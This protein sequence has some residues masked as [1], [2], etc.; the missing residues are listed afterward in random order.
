[1]RGETT[2][3]QEHFATERTM[4][5]SAIE[6]VVFLLLVVGEIV[7]FRTT[8]VTL[9]AGERFLACVSHHM[10]A[11]LG[12]VGE[13]ASTET[14]DVRLDVNRFDVTAV[15]DAVG[16]FLATVLTFKLLLRL[17]HV[18]IVEVDSQ[19]VHA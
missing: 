10:L 12:T 7:G 1:M 8:E 2:R 14:T 19:S 13:S 16:E 3:C 15:H 18:G 6:I 5:V 11:K 4:I 17:L 9:V